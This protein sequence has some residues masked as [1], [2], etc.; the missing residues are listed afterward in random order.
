MNQEFF[1]RVDC[2]SAKSILQNDVKNIA[3]KN[4]FAKWQ[5]ILSNFNFQIEYIK[6]ENNS[7]LDFLTH[8]FCRIHGI[9]APKKT[10][11]S[12]KTTSKPLESQSFKISQ[13]PSPYKMLWCQQVELEEEEQDFIL[14]ILALCLYIYIYIDFYLL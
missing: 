10:T 1:L 7:I 6:G 9:I 5:A 4:I 13:D 8:G 12:P 2:K 14:L 3:S 11:R